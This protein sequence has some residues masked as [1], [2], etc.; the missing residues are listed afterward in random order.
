MKVLVVGS[1]GMLG[2]DL[3]RAFACCSP[4]GLDLPEFNI[5]DARQCLARVQEF[6]PNVIIAAAAL[7]D[8][9]YCESHQDEA[10]LV[11]GRGI[12][13]LAEA[14][15]AAGAA[16]VYY[17]TD[18]VFDGASKDGYVEGDSPNPL[19]VYGRSKLRG[20]EFLRSLC[21]DHLILRT[22][23]LFGGGGRNFIRTI[24][25]AAR[26][27]Q[28]LRVV[29]DQYGSPTYTRDLAAR[30]LVMVEAGCRGTYH[31][32]NSGTCSWYEL[33]LLS[34]QWAGVKDAL[35]KPVRTPEFPRP[36]PRPACSILANA[37]LLAEGFPPMRPWQEAARDY[38][39]TCLSA[40]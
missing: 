16:L 36:A 23:W 12:G 39:V 5:T 30:T 31:L 21:P 27:G 40:T 6:G 19:S 28:P 20:E 26:E 4:P 13:N 25:C 10:F 14:A 3:M 1:R 11:N 15:H 8:V 37:R 38:I 35:I 29:D 22:S 17:S 7:T 9:D 34:L 2:T 33:A 32:T 24:V 18:Y